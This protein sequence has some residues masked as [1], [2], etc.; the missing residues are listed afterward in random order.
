MHGGWWG[1][2][3]YR[4]LLQSSVRLESHKHS[5]STTKATHN[6]GRS[7]GSERGSGVGGG[8]ARHQTSSEGE[9]A[10]GVRAVKARHLGK[11]RQGTEF[12]DDG[13]QRYFG[14]IWIHVGEGGGR[15]GVSGVLG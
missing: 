6:S 5:I 3:V 11:R 13:E 10:D 15:E 8:K 7:G 4:R 1:W 2:G 14:Q 12:P 9:G